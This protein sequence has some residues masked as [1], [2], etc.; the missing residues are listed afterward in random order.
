[1]RDALVFAIHDC[2][3]RARCAVEEQDGGKVRVD[4]ICEI[5]E[6]SRFGIHDLSR[7]E[8]DG[9]TQLPR[10]NMPLEL[11]LFLGARRYG[12]PTQRR[13]QC[14]ILDRERYRFQ[15]YISDLA[16]QDPKAH[17]DQPAKVVGVV[18]NW[19]S[20]HAPNDT[21]LPGARKM[22]TRHALFCDQLPDIL[23]AR[24]IEPGELIYNDYTTIVVQWLEENPW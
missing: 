10:F 11:G 8:A 2:G 5:I 21:M 24:A 3:F 15:R 14:L 6:Q 18:R 12:T 13:K 22:A 9:D 17:D 4:L 7:T 16:G 1:M 23:E 20:H 19:L